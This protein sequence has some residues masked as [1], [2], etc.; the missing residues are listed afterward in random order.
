M[1]DGE[2][3]EEENAIVN[4]S[5]PQSLLDADSNRL[6]LTVVAGDL[7]MDGGKSVVLFR[8][9]TVR[10]LDLRETTVHRRFRDFY[11]VNEALRS[12]YKGSHLLSSFPPLPP[13][14]LKLFE[15]HLSTAF[16][17][18]RRWQLQVGTWGTA[19]LACVANIVLSAVYLMSV[20]LSIAPFVCLSPSLS[21]LSQDWMFKVS[22]VPR[23]RGTPDFLTFLGVIDNER[24]ASLIFPAGSPLGLSFRA[25]PGGSSASGTVEVTA[26]TGDCPVANAALIIRP[27]DK[28]VSEGRGVCFARAFECRD[29]AWVMEGARRHAHLFSLTEI[30]SPLFSP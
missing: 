28:V 27:G 13:R 4:G 18:K 3:V 1:F 17:E 9:H 7:G 12:A 14:S 21:L 19:D 15:D 23:V 30:L 11:A 6:K 5:A 10:E 20:L 22:H 29:V 16:I 2:R 8:L 24:E 25:S 26:V